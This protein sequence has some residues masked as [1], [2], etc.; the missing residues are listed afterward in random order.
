MER[1]NNDILRIILIILGIIVVVWL[2]SKLFMTQ[3]SDNNNN[4]S[5]IVNLSGNQEVQSV[6]TNASGQAKVTL[7][8]DRTA[9][10]YE[11]TTT[12]ASTFTSPQTAAH[13]HLGARGE[14]GPIVRTLNLQPVSATNGQRIYYEKGVW[15]NTDSEPLT[16]ELVNHLLNGNI[17]INIHSEKYP[18]GEIRGQL[19]Y[20][21]D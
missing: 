12:P 10:Y 5:S 2:F 13:F 8:E 15:R 6:D 7:N 19:T 18:D 14:N 4:N 11:I 3:R 1:N 9:L 16:Q 20:S 21:P 17:Y